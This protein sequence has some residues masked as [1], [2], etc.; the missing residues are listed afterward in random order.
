MV[1]GTYSILCLTLL[2]GAC[3]RDHQQTVMIEKPIS[4]RPIV[5]V[6]PVIDKSRHG[7]S[8]N[9][10][11]E[12]T[13]AIRQRLT[14]DDRLYLLSEDQI[15]AMMRKAGE[16]QDPFGL[17]TQW[18]KKA[19][20]QNEFIAF[21]ELV[22]HRELP[23]T[24]TEETKEEGP[25]QLNIAMRVR[26]FDLRENEPKVILQEIVEQSHHVPKQFTRHQFNQVPWGDEMFEISPLGIAH[27]K[28]CQ[29]L[30]NRIEDYILLNCEKTST[31]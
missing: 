7:L 1:R 2:L 19:Y 27:Q 14:Q 30:S 23:L 17:E 25:A 12:L 13:Q 11:Q 28:L 31:R 8:W 26:V 10:S 4:S 3:Q 5:T 9:V 18:I 21:F 16:R 20:P 29:E 6:V 15:Y 24:L 22:E